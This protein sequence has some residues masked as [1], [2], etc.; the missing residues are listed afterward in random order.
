MGHPEPSVDPCGGLGTAMFCRLFGLC[1]AYLAWFTLPVYI[2]QMEHT[3]LVFAFSPWHHMPLHPLGRPRLEAL[4]WLLLSVAAGLF[5]GVMPRACLLLAFASVAYFL[6]L[7][8]TI[9]N[10]HYVLILELCVLLLGVDGQCLSWRPWH[11]SPTLPRWQLTAVQLLILTP[12]LYGAIAKL[13]PSWLQDAEPVRSWADEL[14]GDLD[15]A[16]GGTVGRVIDA[17]VPSHTDVLGC[18][19]FMVAYAGLIFD[20]VSPLLLFHASRPGARRPM[21]LWLTAAACVGFHGMNKLWFGLGVFPWLNLAALC[22]FLVPSHP[23][24]AVRA[25]EVLRH[26]R[27]WPRRLVLLLSIPHTLLPLRHLVWFSGGRSSLWTDEGHLYAWRMKLVEKRG[28]VQ[29]ELRGRQETRRALELAPALAPAYKHANH[30]HS[31]YALRT[32]APLLLSRY[33]GPSTK[34]REFYVNGNDAN[35]LRP[36]LI[37][38]STLTVTALVVVEAMMM[39]IRNESTKMEPQPLSPAIAW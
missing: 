30:C 25:K 35:K 19:A 28:W 21:V 22:V 15:H 13:N 26:R 18:F 20:L 8:R 29:L 31:H 17:V 12:Y 9:Y 34:L 23:P 37:P 32:T 27:R 1:L 10:N 11:P 6:S 3:V 7:D 5:C 24:S 36:I 38:P 16:S 39:K 4:R 2:V 14:L 33:H